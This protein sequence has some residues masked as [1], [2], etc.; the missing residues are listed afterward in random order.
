[1]RAEFPGN[2]E[3]PARLA[4]SLRSPAANL[5]CLAA[6]ALALSSCGVHPGGAP[7]RRISGFPPFAWTVRRGSDYTGRYWALG[8]VRKIDDR[9]EPARLQRSSTWVLPFVWITCRQTERGAGRPPANR[10]DWIAPLLLAG[11]LSDDAFGGYRKSAWLWVLIGRE[12]GRPYDPTQYVHRRYFHPFYAF[13]RTWQVDEHGRKRPESETVRCQLL[14][15][16]F[17][18]QRRGTQ[19][20]RW[21]VLLGLFQYRRDG[22]RKRVDFLWGLYRRESEGGKR[23]HRLFWLLHLGQLKPRRPAAAPKD[24]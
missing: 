24:P 13:E 21:R 10:C 8:L 23:L 15:V 7:P 2:S 14:D 19:F 6:S 5:F 4:S 20:R 22:Q 3:R 9:R 18:Y 11:G 17:R 12:H 1:V 16:V